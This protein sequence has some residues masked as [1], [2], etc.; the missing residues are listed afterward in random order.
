MF[1]PQSKG[2][3]TK[4]VLCMCVCVSV[5]GCLYEKKMLKRQ[6]ALGCEPLEGHQALSCLLRFKSQMLH[7]LLGLAVFTYVLGLAL[8]L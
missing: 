8:G 6:R 7:V 3:L 2:L 1:Q 5:C 4:V